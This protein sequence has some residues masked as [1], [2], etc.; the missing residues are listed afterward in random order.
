MMPTYS[1]GEGIAV[2]DWVRV[3]VPT[4]GVWHHG[5]VLRIFWVGHGFA[6]EVA[7]N[8]KSRGVTASDWYEF[9]GGGVVFLHRRHSTI[10]EV[11]ASL[12]RIEYN[13]GQPYHLFAQNCEHFASFVFSGK[14]QSETVRTVGTIAACVLVIGWLASD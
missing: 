1:T 3:L 7:H 2:G 4:L 10:I 5:V 6:V 13:L 9:S 11:Q 12:A 14:A 8:M